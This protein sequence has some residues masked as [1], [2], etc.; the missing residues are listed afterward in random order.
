MEALKQLHYQENQSSAPAETDYHPGDGSQS[1]DHLKQAQAIIK[2]AT[3]LERSL[4]QV[5][6]FQKI[7]LSGV[8]SNNYPT[9][10]K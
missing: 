1:T 4:P 10:P 3:G 5:R 9:E 8:K 2:E 7:N 6:A